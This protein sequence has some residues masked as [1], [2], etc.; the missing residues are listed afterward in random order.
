MEKDSNST[1]NPRAIAAT[2]LKQRLA[3]KKGKPSTK[4]K[5]AEANY[6]KVAAKTPP[7]EGGRFKAMEK[8]AK[9]KGA[10]DPGALAAYIGRK[11][12]GDKKFNK[13]AQEGKK[14]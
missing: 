14:A 5:K 9:A 12:Y 13:M 11:K 7:G 2:K 3:R 10:K 8:V 1:K 4:V 6:K